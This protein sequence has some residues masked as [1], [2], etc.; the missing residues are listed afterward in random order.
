MASSQLHLT[1]SLFCLA[2]AASII[3]C[4]RSHMVL[5]S[6]LQASHGSAA[7][8]EMPER[9]SL[10]ELQWLLSNSDPAAI[11]SDSPSLGIL[12]NELDLMRR[13][14]GDKERKPGCK[15][16]FWKSRTAC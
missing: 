14:S 3:S 9:Y 13:D 1:V 7:D 6:A 5:N 8:E 4:G 10:P 12:Q 2:M 15:N 11:Q 16:Y